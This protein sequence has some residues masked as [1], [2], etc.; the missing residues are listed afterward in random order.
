[1]K[2]VSNCHWREPLYLG[3]LTPA[4]LREV[5][6]LFANNWDDELEG[7]FQDERGDG[8]PATAY[9]LTDDEL[10]KAAEKLSE[11]ASPEFTRYRGALVDLGEFMCTCQLDPKDWTP[12]R[13]IPALREL[14]GWDGYIS[15]S[16]FNGLVIRWGR[17]DEIDGPLFQIGRYYS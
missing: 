12:R 6:Y 11:W 8:E 16:H 15:H 7:L 1:M 5:D 4:E 2:I 9:T 17:W 14:G 10:V 3:D 13:D